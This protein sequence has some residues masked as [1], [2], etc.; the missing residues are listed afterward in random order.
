M[1][2][3]YIIEVG[4]ENEEYFYFTQRYK[5]ISQ[6]IYEREHLPGKHCT[7]NMWLIKPANMNQGR[8]IEVIRNLREFKANITSKPLHST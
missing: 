8:G 3:S 2:T 4:N 1:A 6:N 7:Q 5:E